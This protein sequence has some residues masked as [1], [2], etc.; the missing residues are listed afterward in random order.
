MARLPDSSR[1]ASNDRAPVE[2]GLECQNVHLNPKKT[3]PHPVKESW[4]HLPAT[5]N[6]EEL[7]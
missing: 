4:S 3:D 6:Q 7:P 5:C 2:G 1:M